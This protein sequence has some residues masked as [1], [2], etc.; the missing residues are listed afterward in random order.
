MKI[1]LRINRENDPHDTNL[2]A[3]GSGA[4]TSTNGAHHIRLDAHWSLTLAT[5]LLVFVTG[6]L[7]WATFL[8][9]KTEK[10]TKTADEKHVIINALDRLEKVMDYHTGTRNCIR[11]VLRE[12]LV[13]TVYYSRSLNKWPTATGPDSENER[14]A[15]LA[16]LYETTANPPFPTQWDY[17]RGQ[18]WPWLNALD[19]AALW[20]GQAT[21]SEHTAA[22]DE[23]DWQQDPSGQALLRME[24]RDV[25][26]DG[27]L[28][29]LRKAS[30]LVGDSP[31]V[32]WQIFRV[33][34]PPKFN[35][36]K[37][38]KPSQ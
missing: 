32:D 21:P 26:D 33:K 15:C 31:H 37:T 29:F 4:A 20:V 18:I 8:L 36:D 28:C 2:A 17:M 7:A 19:A 12:G 27:T 16:G 14:K 22:R 6:L 13:K 3:A 38:L 24:L 30:D 11:Y 23:E 9:D 35:C 34:K 5:V 10:A 1:L 25:A